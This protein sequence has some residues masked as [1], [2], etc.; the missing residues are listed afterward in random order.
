VIHIFRG[1]VILWCF[2]G[3]RDMKKLMLMM[4]MMMVV[5][6]R[7]NISA[8]SKRFISQHLSTMTPSPYQL[9]VCI[10]H[11]PDTQNLISSFYLKRIFFLS[12]VT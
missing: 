3:F 2:F 7:Y 6:V 1:F 11:V 4:M 10:V 8:I 5:V 12:D 9:F